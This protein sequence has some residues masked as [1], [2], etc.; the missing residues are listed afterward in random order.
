MSVYYRLLEKLLWPS[1][2]WHQ[3]LNPQPLDHKSPPITSRPVLPPIIQII[4]YTL[5]RK[6]KNLKTI[7]Q[8]DFKSL[9]FQSSKLSTWMMWSSDQV[10]WTHFEFENSQKLTHPIATSTTYRGNRSKWFHVSPNRWYSFGASW[11]RRS[12]SLHRI[13]HDP[14]SNLNIA[15][16]QFVNFKSYRSNK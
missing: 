8:E 9:L 13:V 7:L 11:Y 14:K 1:S 12:W 15:S 4:T 3:D 16:W 2:I 5:V 10:Y 6:I